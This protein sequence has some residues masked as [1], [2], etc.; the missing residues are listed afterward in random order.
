ML[1]TKMEITD[2]S[3]GADATTLDS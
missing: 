1:S 2:Q 3:V